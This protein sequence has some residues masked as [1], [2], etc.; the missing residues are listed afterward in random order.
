MEPDPWLAHHLFIEQQA[1]GTPGDEIPGLRGNRLRELSAIITEV[2]L[3][4]GEGLPRSGLNRQNQ[5]EG[6][7]MTSLG[8]LSSDGL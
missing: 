3:V 5:W 6:D 8:T 4:S 7:Q 2:L 1:T